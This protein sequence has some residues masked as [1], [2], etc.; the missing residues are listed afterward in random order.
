[1]IRPRLRSRSAVAALAALACVSAATA[2]AARHP[3]GPAEDARQS[4]VLISLD[5][6]RWD[7]INRPEAKNLR[8]LAAHGVRA[9]RLVPSFPSLTFPNHYTIVTGLY[10]EHHGIVSNAMVDPV[11]GR[12]ASGDNPAV[13]DARWWGGEPIWV[14]A[15]RQHERAAP[16]A[17]PGAEAPIGGVRPTWW[18]KYDVNAS[19]A[20]RVR[21]VL[22]LLALPADSAPR[23]ITE[24]FSEVDH[25]GHVAGP[26]SPQLDTAIAQLDSAVGAIVDGITRLGLWNRVDLIVLA[27]HG[28]AAMSMSRFIVLDDY[29]SL[30]SLEIIEGG[31]VEEIV[32][33]PGHERYVYDHLHGANP[34]LAVY[35]KGEL[36]ARFHYNDNPRITPIVAIADEG[37]A[38]TTRSRLLAKVGPFG[39]NH[40][41]DNQLLSMGALFV[42]SGPAFKSGVVVPPFQNI[43]V[44]DLIA[45]LL[46]LRPAPN[47]GSLDS[48]R[49]LLKTR[50]ASSP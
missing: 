6:F 24:Y 41:Y 49:V 15:E 26:D 31:P 14:T 2:C 48:T 39:G 17:W 35:R 47:D 43:H 23:F 10:P 45:H 9:E 20:D 46:G 30:D 1:M 33:K 25:Q 19:R 27:D 42:A 18:E 22:S 4:V 34:H 3:A 50:A 12:F 38:T 8:A 21:K 7:Y 13:R 36:P 32:P 37:W 5:G 11:L 28:M 29:V 40:G 44:Y 16:Y